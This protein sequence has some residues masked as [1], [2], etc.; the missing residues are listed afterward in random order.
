M[1]RKPGIS[2]AT[3]ERARAS[4]VDTNNLD[5][6]TTPGNPSIENILNF[7]SGKRAQSI[8]SKGTAALKNWRKH[9]RFLAATAL[10]SAIILYSPE[11]SAAAEPNAVLTPASW[12][13]IHASNVDWSAIGRAIWTFWSG[14][15]TALFIARAWRSKKK[16]ELI[17]AFIDFLKQLPLGE[18][19]T[20]VER[21]AA[22]ISNYRKARMTETNGTDEADQAPKQ[23]KSSQDE[24]HSV[25][26]LN[27]YGASRKGRR[28]DNQDAFEIVQPFSDEALLIVADGVGGHPGGKITARN[29]VRAASDFALRALAEKPDDMSEIECLEH[30]IVQTRELAVAEHWPG[31]TTLI[32]AHIKGDRLTYATLGDGGL[33]AIYPGGI[34]APLL[35]PHHH[36]DRPNNVI[37]AY[38]GQECE[39]PPRVG[40]VKLEF[41]TIILAMSDGVSELLDYDELGSNHQSLAEAMRKGGDSDKVAGDILLQLEQARDLETNAILHSDN[42]TLAMALLDD[43]ACQSASEEQQVATIGDDHG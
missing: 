13:T 39:V 23:D 28:S 11:A 32:L 6:R 5:R 37:S 43:A 20:A 33:T 17:A 3:K 42:M 27:I 24:E 35:I 25:F 4:G 38:I 31:M 21:L 10:T 15:M 9:L 12:L 16:Q 22:E 36:H 30:A 2:K 29:T 14:S 7:R 41:G 26:R 34:V 40:S 18:Y 1:T 8:L 19:L